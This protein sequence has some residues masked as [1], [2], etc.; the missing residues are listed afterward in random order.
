MEQFASVR[1]LFKALKMPVHVMCGNHDWKSN[2]DRAAFE[3][4]HGNEVNYT[5]DHNGWQ[6]V[7]LD[8]TH[9]LRAE[10]TIQ[11]HTLDF[12]E[13]TLPKIATDRPMVLLT[14]FPLGEKVPMRPANADLLLEQFK[15]HNLRAVFG[16]HHHGFTERTRGDIVLTTNRCCSFRRNNHDGTK[17]KGYFVCE[18]KEAKVV[19]E[20]VEVTV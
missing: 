3:Q 5:F 14:H 20:F 13:R 9:G 7:A 17:E 1:D 18:T 6:F 16:G 12:S 11:K 2:E 15:Q 19:R 10:V 8:S 4:M